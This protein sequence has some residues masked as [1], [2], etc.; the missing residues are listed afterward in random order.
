MV[1]NFPKI[2]GLILVVNLLA[3]S[4][5]AQINGF[6]RIRKGESYKSVRVKMLKAGWK[7]YRSPDADKCRTGD[8]RCK[9][10]PEMQSCSGTGTAACRFLWKRKAKTVVI[11]T[12]GEFEAVYN[13]HDFVK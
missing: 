4:V 10:R 8:N 6:P 2:G 9:G 13:G 1:I 3:F 7:P 11:F 5:S 12:V